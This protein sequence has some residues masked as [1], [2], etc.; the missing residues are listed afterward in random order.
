MQVDGHVDVVVPQAGTETE[1]AVEEIVSAVGDAVAAGQVV[2][3]VEMDKAAVEITSPV[4]GEV[5]E[6]LVSVGAE[7][8]P[9]DVLFRVRPHG[10]G[11]EA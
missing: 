11:A 7:V 1:G 6:I 5:A 2:M 3:V 8:T 4:D 9:G 10:D